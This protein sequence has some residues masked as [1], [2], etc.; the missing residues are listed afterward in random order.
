LLFDAVERVIA[1]PSAA[2]PWHAL[3]KAMA[4]VPELPIRRQ[5][6]K[7]LLVHTPTEGSAGFLRETLLFSATRDIR[8]LSAA[9]RLL[10]RIAPYSP[11]RVAAFLNF[12]WGTLLVGSP[13]REGFLPLLKAANFHSLTTA[14]GRHIAPGLPRLPV[15]TVSAVRSVAVIAPHLSNLDHAPTALALNHAALLRQQGFAVQVL[16]AQEQHVPDMGGYFGGGESTTI[17]PPDRRGWRGMM[18]DGVSL[19]LGDSRFSLPARWNRLAT[20]LVKFDPDLI[21]FAG[22]Q[23]PLVLPYFHARPVAALS[24]HTIPPPLPHDV[25]LCADEARAGTDDATW[26]PVLPASEAWHYPWRLALKPVREPLSRETLGL[27]SKSLALLSVGDRLVHEITPGWG[28]A[29]LRF[30]DAHPDAE[31]LLVGGE[32]TL[33]PALGAGHP[34]VKTL[35][36][37]P[38]IRAIC[39]CID[40]YVNPPRMGGGFSVATAMAEGRPVASHAGSDGGDKIGALASADDAAFFARLERLATDAGER[41]A[42]GEALRA[43]YAQTLDLAA[44]GP[45]LAAACERALARYRSR[46]KTT[47][48]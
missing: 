16:S 12:A 17:A 38:D 2:E 41:R 39:G 21:L 37:H 34:R 27:A 10:Y 7:R 28:T 6:L 47:S 25:W 29:M 32:G 24:L 15:R 44:A 43:R 46:V 36:H 13:G 26:A 45:S 31:W 22:F 11:D 35:R 4:K 42:T 19:V 23:S 8:H 1:N 14:L 5:A 33:P 20:L 40:I 48:S 9:S 30:L 18:P 3:A